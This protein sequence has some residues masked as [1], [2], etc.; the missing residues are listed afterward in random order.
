VDEARCCVSS[1]AD[2][3]RC[4]PCRFDRKLSTVDH[5]LFSRSD[6]LSVYA[7]MSVTCKVLES[8]EDSATP[9]AFC[10]RCRCTAPNSP[11]GAEQQA[12]HVS[13][14]DA[15]LFRLCFCVR[16]RQTHRPRL[17]AGVL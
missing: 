14:V 2:M 10:C 5:L 6:L 17:S 8:A 3:S 4:A 15:V 7:D 16:R 13:R 9:Q 1:L 11:P 12:W